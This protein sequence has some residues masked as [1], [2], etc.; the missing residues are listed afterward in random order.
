MLHLQRKLAE[1]ERVIRQEIDSR[2]LFQRLMVNIGDTTDHDHD[3]V[4]MLDDRERGVLRRAL[5]RLDQD[6]VIS[7][8][9]ADR[10]EQQRRWYQTVSGAIIGFGGLLVATAGVVLGYVQALRH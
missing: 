8:Y 4:L 3:C 2:K 7:A 6:E 1:L 10:R 9:F 5:D